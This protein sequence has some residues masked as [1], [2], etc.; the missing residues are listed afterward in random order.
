MSKTE[1]TY[2][3]PSREAIAAAIEACR[4]EAVR[5]DPPDEQWMQH[6][7]TIAELHEAIDWTLDQLGRL[8]L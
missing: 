7:L 5:S 8:G 4:L 1:R 2:R 3:V 6:M